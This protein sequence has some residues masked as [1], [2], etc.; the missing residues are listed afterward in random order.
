MFSFSYFVSDFLLESKNHNVFW[1]CNEKIKVSPFSYLLE[2]QLIHKLHVI[3][4]Q[5][6]Q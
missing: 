6:I 2:L 5:I 3:Y 4:L 1:K